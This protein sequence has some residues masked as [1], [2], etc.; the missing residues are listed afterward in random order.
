MHT[1]KDNKVKM[2]WRQEQLNPQNDIKTIQ[3]Y[4]KIVTKWIDSLQVFLGKYQL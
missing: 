3:G 2:N 4:L 1:N